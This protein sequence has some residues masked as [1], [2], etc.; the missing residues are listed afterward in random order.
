MLEN[1]CDCGR[2]MRADSEQDFIELVTVHLKY[3][4]PERAETLDNA[5]LL[6]L[7]HTASTRSS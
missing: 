2:I 6:K 3:N 5:S 7:V 1:T 4:H